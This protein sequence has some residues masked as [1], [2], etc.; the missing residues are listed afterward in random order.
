MLNKQQNTT[1][2]ALERKSSWGYQPAIDGLRS[3]AVV[4]VLLFHFDQ[5]FLGGGFVGFDAFFVIPG[6]LI[7][8]VLLPDIKQ[9]RFL[10][11]ASISCAL[12]EY[13]RLRD[14]HRGYARLWLA[15]LFQS[16]F[17]VARCERRRRALSDKRQALVSR[18]LS[19]I[20]RR[21]PAAPPLFN[22]RR[23]RAIL[24]DF[25]DLPLSYHASVPKHPTY[26]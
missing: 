15:H 8:S 9:S 20:V 7:G 23:R 19:C 6:Y 3:V 12:P 11:R 25:S 10:W 5:R 14:D 1:S 22:P 24:C 2:P 13:S 18:K 21:R 26:C 17:C 16:G 4:S